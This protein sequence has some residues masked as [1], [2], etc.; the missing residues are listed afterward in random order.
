MNELLRSSSVHSKLLQIM[1]F[2]YLLSSCPLWHAGCSGLMVGSRP[3]HHGTM[4]PGL[5][6]GPWSPPQMRSTTKS[7]FQYTW[8]DVTRNTVHTY[9]HTYTCIYMSTMFALTMYACAFDLRMTVC[10]I[11]VRKSIHVYA[12]GNPFTWANI[13]WIIEFRF[14]VVTIWNGKFTTCKSIPKK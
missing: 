1:Q 3:E 5:C 9:I 12:G 14:F 2:L 13:E 7:T 10:T 11:W 8:V 6:S 4:W